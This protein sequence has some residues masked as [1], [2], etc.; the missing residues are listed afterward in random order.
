MANGPGELD[1]APVVGDLA[2]MR[3][4]EARVL[5][6]AYER[7]HA[8]LERARQLGVIDKH[9][10]RISKEWP[11]EMRPLPASST[12]APVDLDDYDWRF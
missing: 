6:G 1:K 11:L 10:N 7:I 5:A 2:H 3:E 9:G 4:V 8:D 12:G